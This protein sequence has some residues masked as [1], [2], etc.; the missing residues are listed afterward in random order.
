MSGRKV[1]ILLMVVTFGLLLISNAALSRPGPPLH[2][3]IPWHASAGNPPDDPPIDDPDGIITGDDDN[4]DRPAGHG[5][6]VAEVGALED[7]AGAETNAD[8]LDV[9]APLTE[10]S[11]KVRLGILFRLWTMTFGLR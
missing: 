6:T 2:N 4:W 8:A 9:R 10:V 11:W 3:E 5:H 1:L 7:G